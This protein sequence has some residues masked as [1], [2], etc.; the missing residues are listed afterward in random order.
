M[1]NNIQKKKTEYS[2]FYL[3]GYYKFVSKL[4]GIIALLFLGPLWTYTILDNMLDEIIVLDVGLSLIFASGE[5]FF[6]YRVLRASKP[7][8][9]I[10]DNGFI[11]KKQLY[12]WNR[13]EKTVIGIRQINTARP[14]YTLMSD[15]HYLRV[16]FK[17][18]RNTLDIVTDMTTCGDNEER[19]KLK[20]ALSRHCHCVSEKMPNWRKNSA[21][22]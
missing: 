10:T 17:D 15:E 16:F 21:I 5:A 1:K 19:N 3:A 2:I 9:E 8:V 14:P 7:F 6:L 13:I 20:Q 22:Y 4:L 12:S 11:Y 18:G